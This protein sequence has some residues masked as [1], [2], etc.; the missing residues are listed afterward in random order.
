MD[1]ARTMG[2]GGYVCVACRSGANR[3]CKTKQFKDLEIFSGATRD[4]II[5]RS[6]ISVAADYGLFAGSVAIT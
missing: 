5:C 4:S 6:G 3:S 2:W 1:A